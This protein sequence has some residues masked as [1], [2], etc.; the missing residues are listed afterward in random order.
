MDKDTLVRLLKGEHISVAERIERGI[1]YHPP[2]KFNEL[3]N[4]LSEILSSQPFFPND[5]HLQKS[6]HPVYEGAVIEKVS[7]TQFVYH[8][9]RSNAS[10]PY[11][12]AEKSKK[13]FKSARDVARH[14][15]ENELHLPGDLDGFKVI[16]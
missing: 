16:K 5:E 13:H 10:D 1:N 8:L 14:Y 3:L 6:G 15:L 7:E 9:Q 11:F 12:V 2:L 4:V